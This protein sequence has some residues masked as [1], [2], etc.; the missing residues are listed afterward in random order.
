MACGPG[1]GLTKLN[2]LKDAAMGAV[3]G[4]TS[5]AEGIM[6]SLDSLGAT[7]DAQVSSIA[8]GLKEMLPTIELPEL[9]TIPEFKI[10]ELKLPELSLQLE[11]GSIINKIKSNNP[12]DKAQALKNLD[13]LQDKFPDMDLTSLTAD[14]KAGKIDIDNLCKMVPNVEKIDGVFQIKGIPATAPEIDAESIAAF[15]ISVDTAGLEKAASELV[16]SVDQDKL[17]SALANITASIDIEKVEQEKEQIK[18]I[19]TFIRM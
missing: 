13:S 2:G 19:S 16:E 14:I 1:K 9:P 10:P 15:A 8:G 5:G 6:G 12:L 17:T 7:L 18:S 4:L 3:D 11:V